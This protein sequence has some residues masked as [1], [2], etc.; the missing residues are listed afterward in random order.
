[1]MAGVLLNPQY[2]RINI[3]LSM[4]LEMKINSFA[5]GENDMFFSKT[6]KTQARFSTRR[7]VY[8]IYIYIYIP[9]GSCRATL[10]N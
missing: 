5:N 1:M 9:F 10:V 3:C 6:L 4:I 7:V 2:K 8:D